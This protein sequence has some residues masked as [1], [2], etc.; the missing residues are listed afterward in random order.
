MAK[1]SS[2]EATRNVPSTSAAAK[3]L[4]TPQKE[5]AIPQNDVP[6]QRSQITL[7]PSPC[8]SQRLF[9]SELPKTSK[10]S[11]DKISLPSTIQE[12]AEP[13]V[14]SS[15]EPSPLKI[16]TRVITSPVSAGTITSSNTDTIYSGRMSSSTRH[17]TSPD[18][19]EAS[20]AKTTAPSIPAT[21]DVTSAAILTSPAKDKSAAENIP[22]VEAKKIEEEA[23]VIVKKS[24]KESAKSKSPATPRSQKSE[25]ASKTPKLAAKFGF[26]GN[27]HS[28][29]QKVLPSPKVKPKKGSLIIKGKSGKLFK[30]VKYCFSFSRSEHK[31]S[32]LIF[33][34][35]FVTRVQNQ[36]KGCLCCAP[37]PRF[38][39]ERSK[40]N[41]I[42]EKRYCTLVSDRERRIM[43]YNISHIFCTFFIIFKAQLIPSSIKNGHKNLALAVL[44]ET[45]IK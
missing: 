15:A 43:L 23:T 12:V 24:S 38:F 19:S 30:N 5:E 25:K 10:T 21:T 20:N 44:S 16:Q 32:R 2:M 9:A 1:S 29:A 28:K 45:F 42:C 4:I 18:W 6:L 22:P 37:S 3:T 26:G 31:V 40:Q 33:A 7:I 8:R 35:A 41:L 17:I 36:P 14:S 34:Y 13:T 27:K 39:N 11:E